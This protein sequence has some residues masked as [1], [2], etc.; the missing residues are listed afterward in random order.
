MNKPSPS[1][2]WIHE[3]SWP[4]IQAYLDEDDVVLL[5]I[6]ATEQHGRHLPLL[7]DTGWAIAASEG[8]ARLSHALIAPPLHLGWSPHHLGYP[9]SMTL[10]PETLTQVTLEMAESLVFHGFKRVVIVN[11]NRIANLPPLEIAASKI[12][13][14][15][16]ALVVVADVGLV[17]KQEIAALKEG[18][19]GTLDHAGESETAF[20]MAW[21][22]ELVNLDKAET[23]LPPRPS[24]FDE[25]LE[26]EPEFSGNAVSVVRIAAKPPADENDTASQGISGDPSKATAE[27]GQAMLDAIARN[28]AKVIDELRAQETPKT[29][30]E[31]PF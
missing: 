11:G 5:P 13:H 14:K 20:M 28:I 4:V 3:L 16:G 8:A 26:F 18:A 9:G 21:R 22:P 19:P 24:A 2:P 30:A 10:R 23:H 6:G 1:S 17:A 27:K 25:P 15:T 31:V 12:R 29:R 7:V